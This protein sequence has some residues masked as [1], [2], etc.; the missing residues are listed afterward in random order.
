MAYQTNLL[1][2]KAA[3]YRFA[4]FVRVGAPLVAIMLVVLSFL[5]AGRYGL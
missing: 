5:L 3:G 1:V 4:D 2:M